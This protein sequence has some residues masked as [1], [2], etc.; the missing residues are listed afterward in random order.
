MVANICVPRD[1]LKAYLAG[2]VDPES[3]EDIESHLAS[4]PVCE[5]TIAS[6]ESDPETL[7]EAIRTVRSH[8]T[9]GSS[10]G[11]T[12]G[13]D[14]D[15]VASPTP[16]EAA[17]AAAREMMD[18]S[19]DPEVESSSTPLEG[20]IGAYELI[21]PIGRGGMGSVYLARHKQLKKE[22]AIKLLPAR[23]HHHQHFV[24]RFQREIRAAGGLQHTAIVQATDAGEHEGTQYLVMEYIDG[25]DLSRLG[26]CVGQLPVA[27]ACALVRRVALGLSHAHAAGVVHRDIKPSNLMVS[28]DGAVK[29]LDFGLAR[30]GPWDEVSAELTTVGQLMGTL[31]YM[32]PEQAERAESVDYRADLYSLGA[33][34]FRLLCGR[35]PLSAAPDLSPLAKLRLLAT[36]EPPRLTTLRP[37]VPESLG[38]IVDSML[39]RVPDERPASAAHIAESLEP[40]TGDSDLPRLVREAM[41]T[42]SEN[43]SESQSIARPQMAPASIQSPADVGP[44]RSWLAILAIAALPFLLVAGVLVALET[45]KGELVIRSEAD[46]S[47]QLLKDG[48]VYRELQVVPGNQSTRLYAGRYEV[49]IDGASDLV[50]IGNKTITIQRGE[51]ELATISKSSSGGAPPASDAILQP[52]DLLT[53]SSPTDD[54]L[55]WTG[56]VA[57][58]STIRVPLIGDVSLAGKTL[59]EAQVALEKAYSQKIKTPAFDLF[60][61]EERRGKSAMVAPRR[62]IPPASTAPVQPG[63]G[64]S[65][66]SITDDTLRGTAIVQADHTIRVVMIGTVDVRGMTVDEAETALNNA[67]SGVVRSPA[68]TL[69][70]DFTISAPVPEVPLNQTGAALAEEPSALSSIPLGSSESAEPDY[71][72]V[73]YRGRPL[74]EW[75]RILPLERSPKGVFDV[76]EALVNLGGPETS[77]VIVKTLCEVLPKQSWPTYATNDVGMPLNLHAKAFG[78][79][80]S[81]EEGYGEYL[82]DQLKTGE[83]PWRRTIIGKGL[84]GIQGEQLDPFH[85]WMF[86]VGFPAGGELA[87]TV[88]QYFT[89]YINRKE[90]SEERRQ[91]LMERL[92]KVESLDDDFWLAPVKPNSKGPVVQPWVNLAK[93]RALR[94]IVSE[95]STPIQI[96]VAANALKAIQGIQRNQA[97]YGGAV[98]S[99]E[100]VVDAAVARIRSLL[101]EPAALTEAHEIPSELYPDWFS[102]LG[103][104]S[105]NWRMVG[106]ANSQNSLRRCTLTRCLLQLI[107]RGNLSSDRDVSVLRE[108]AEQ[109]LEPSAR[110][111]ASEADRNLEAIS[112]TSRSLMRASV[113]SRGLRFMRWRGAPTSVRPWQADDEEPNARGFRAYLIFYESILRLT[114]A[115][116]SQLI[117]ELFTRA[118]EIQSEL[119]FQKSDADDDGALSRT[120][121]KSLAESQA[122]RFQ[123]VEFDT[124]DEDGDGAVSRVEV[125]AFG[126]ENEVRQKT[127]VMELSD[128]IVEYMRRTFSRSD[129]NSDGLLSQDEISKMLIKPKGADTD[130][131]G[132]VTLQEYVQFRYQKSKEGT[133]G[134]TLGR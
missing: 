94:L 51:I 125:S 27:S 69:L 66:S 93:E 56:R 95:E 101:E 70:R 130:G 17:L 38:R 53:F 84:D 109:N 13:P 106:G 16:V 86:D 50:E 20:N 104:S 1:E 33:T 119:Q 5:E 131:D 115:E 122:S 44:G 79:L 114:G 26:R 71:P 88:A 85:T 83:D 90:K 75:L 111:I 100:D 97:R 129:T 7:L 82:L 57:A 39:S 118:A 41:E 46:V 3:C 98:P 112:T 120:E 58:D 4:C 65:Y 30:V 128:E 92:L 132:A 43:A 121:Y 32:A 117:D 78:F 31:D 18:V 113:D 59:A 76:L 123:D 133:W 105:S 103:I 35:P 37:D 108:L 9:A 19:S 8:S 74:S 14:L 134:P 45:Q 2:W 102:T 124:V 67:Y 81:N 29:I 96:A 126:K 116:G 12:A 15:Q 99:I 54:T 52:G 28:Q 107:P 49:T 34:L 62:I 21:R 110:F 36:T 72:D 127:P 55:E 47:V 48:Q 68:I 80:Q 60:R 64:L 89:T 25:M 63:D 10:S 73:L 6:M 42:A 61:A 11:R 22:V 91:Q 24:A 87:S 40:F 23:S 77:P